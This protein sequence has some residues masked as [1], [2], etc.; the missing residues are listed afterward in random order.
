MDFKIECK[1]KFH[2]ENESGIFFIEK[3]KVMGFH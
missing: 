2:F 1:H 3:H